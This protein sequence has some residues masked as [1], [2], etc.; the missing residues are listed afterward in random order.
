MLI[1]ILGPNL[2]NKNDKEWWL[3]GWR[4][5]D[6]YSILFGTG[7]SKN[8][9][10]TTRGLPSVPLF[11]VHLLYFTICH[12][13]FNYDCHW[14]PRNIHISWIYFMEFKIYSIWCSRYRRGFKEAHSW[15]ILDLDLACKVPVEPCS[16]QRCK[17]FSEAIMNCDSYMPSGATRVG[18]CHRR[19]YRRCRRRCNSVRVKHANC[20]LF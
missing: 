11:R 18:S 20:Q 7:V 19:H 15:A 12:I 1:S 17:Y 16:K 2:H 9:S 13:V 6:R 8:R 14:E 3:A 5:D 4:D 10:I